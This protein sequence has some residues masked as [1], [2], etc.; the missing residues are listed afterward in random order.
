MLATRESKGH[1][2]PLIYEHVVL[3]VHICILFTECKIVMHDIL[4][5][6]SVLYLPVLPDICV[7]GNL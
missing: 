7:G 4:H 5:Q 1:T 2:S 3:T 6:W